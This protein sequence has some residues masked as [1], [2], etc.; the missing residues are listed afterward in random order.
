MKQKTRKLSIRT[1]LLSIIGALLIIIVIWLSVISYISTENN[2]ISMASHQAEIAATIA[3]DELDVEKLND[4]SHGDESHTDYI[5]MRTALI[6]VQETCG[7]K[8]LYT[9]RTDTN[10]VTYVIDTD[11]SGNRC[12][13]GDEFEESYEDLKSIFDGEPYISNEIEV[14]DDGALI[15]AYIPIK[16]SSGNVVG[17]LGSDYDASTVQS[18]L[19]RLRLEAIVI[20]VI[21]LV[22]SLGITGIVITSITNNL[23]KVNSKLYELVHNEGDLTQTI[24]VKS[25]DES[26][27]LATNVNDLVAYIRKIMI[28][29][30]ENAVILNSSAREVASELTIAGEGIS[31]LS[32]TMQQMSASMEET[33]ATLNQVTDSVNNISEQI[34]HIESKASE[35]NSTTQKITEY[36][37][38]LHNEANDTQNK[39]KISVSEMSSLV[40]AKI[41]Q[42]KAVDEINTL[43]NDILGISSQTN[44]LALNASIEAA[45]AGEA[46]KGFAVVADEISTLA[47]N[48]A[49]AATKIQ[50]VSYTVVEAVKGLAAASE[51]MLKFLNETTMTGY[52]QLLTTAEKY[53]SEM[54][55]INEMM[56]EFAQIAKDVENATTVICEAIEA[57]DIAVE[58]S[59]KGI[60]TVSETAVN[61]TDTV[62]TIK[63]NAD[64]N[65]NVSDSLNAEVSKFKLQ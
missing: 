23:K 13:I 1:K 39:A 7:I 8:Y 52:D 50:K 31:D 36:A 62:T 54:T 60:I 58:E 25:G 6:N 16:D 22:I 14:T 26:E 40:N 44:L 55:Q 18:R 27:L 17:I 15:T 46:G 28:Q 47:T 9:L 43:T 61:L 24:N 21:S 34:S 2:L 42:A 19:D 56:T 45:R 38:T 35:C 29:I 32:A 59:S 64:N 30:S 37:V 65:S 41:E 51:Q 3:L 57:V 5:S 20:G 4:L 11:Q 63:S 48:S 12:S 10:T 49:D 33:T 53:S